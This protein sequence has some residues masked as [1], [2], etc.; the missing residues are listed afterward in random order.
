MLLLLACWLSIS[1]LLPLVASSSSSGF[2][3]SSSS[4]A[5]TA[6]AAA[7]AARLYSPT[8][9]GPSPLYFT[10]EMTTHARL[11]VQS[12][13]ALTNKQ[14]VD[15][16]L[17]DEALAQALFTLPDT[18]VV[19]HGLQTQAENGPVLNYGNA[20]ALKRW[21]AS[22]EQLT[23]MPSRFTAEPMEREARA[24]FMAQVT[25][26]GIVNDYQGVRI[27]LDGK[28]FCM[29]EA[30]VWNI[31]VDGQLYGQAACFSKWEDV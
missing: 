17:S 16:S 4:P 18:V 28:R 1:L 11:V 2:P 19:S 22:W 10:Q 27:G 14:L 12:Y 9:F 7:A 5:S 21:G 26:K 8:F 31:V 24:A 25:S 6:A 3:S 20:A 29:K 30:S 23:S 15:L 13:H